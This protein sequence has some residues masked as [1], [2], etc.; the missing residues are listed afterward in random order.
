MH[1]GV[2][3]FLYNG[4]RFAMKKSYRAERASGTAV[5]NLPASMTR[6]IGRIVVHWAYFEYCVQEMNWQSLGIAPAQGRIALRE[7][8]ASERLEMLRDLVKLRHGTWDDDL[9]L[10]ILTRAKLLTS[11]RHL[12]AHGIWANRE[13]GWYVEL[14]RGSWPKN[15]AELVAGSKKVTPELVSMDTSKLRKATNEIEALIQDLKRL[16]TSAVVSYPSSPETR[17]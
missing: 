2:I 16:R 8:R 7:P 12:I 17:P 4:S 9:Y 11:K 3:L 6:E 15:L 1:Q 13:D 14:A 10:S 5:Y